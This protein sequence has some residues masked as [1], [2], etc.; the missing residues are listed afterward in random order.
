[1]QWDLCPL[2]N[3]RHYNDKEDHHLSDVELLS[4]DMFSN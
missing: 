4:C 3:R 2:I 1:M